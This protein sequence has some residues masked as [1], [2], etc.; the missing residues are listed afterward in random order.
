[1]A[2]FGAVLKPARRCERLVRGVG[3]GADGCDSSMVEMCGGG[4]LNRFTLGPFLR[5]PKPEL[6]AP[7]ELPLLKDGL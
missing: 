2:D 5:D 3:M 6:G 7:S 1:M 4:T